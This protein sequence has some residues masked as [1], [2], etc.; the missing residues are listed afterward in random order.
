MVFI[1]PAFVHQQDLL[2]A[3][4]STRENF[5]M[6][7]LLWYASALSASPPEICDCCKARA[8]SLLMMSLSTKFWGVLFREFS[9]FSSGLVDGHTRWHVFLCGD[10]YQAP[11]LLETRLAVQH[12]AVT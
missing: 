3:T 7:T 4:Q 6:V 9:T 1:K 8:P 11:T 10:T 5:Q 2:K 12:T